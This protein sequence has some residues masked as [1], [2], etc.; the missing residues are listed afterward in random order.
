MVSIGILEYRI[1]VEV[2]N[3]YI[4]W[5]GIEVKQERKKFDFT[6]KLSSYWVSNIYNGNINISKP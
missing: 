1:P 6:T 2:L 5:S 3:K 4:I